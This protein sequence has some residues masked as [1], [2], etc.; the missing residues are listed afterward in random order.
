VKFGGTAGDLYCPREF[1]Y[2]TQGFRVYTVDFVDY[3][4]QPDRLGFAAC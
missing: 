4:I 2:L 3:N 1:Q